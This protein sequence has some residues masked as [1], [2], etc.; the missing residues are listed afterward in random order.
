MAAWVGEHLLGLGVLGIGPTG[1]GDMAVHYVEVLMRVLGA[2]ALSLIW[3]L[4]DRHRPH[5]RRL[6]RWLVVGCRYYLMSVMLA[7]GFAK[8]FSGQF[9]PPTL[10][11]LL[12][13]FGDASPMGL[14]W[15]FMGASKAYSAFA[16]L[17]EVTGGLLLA[18]RRTTTLGA[19]VIVAVMS[20]V[21]M[22]NFSYDVPVKL[23]SCHLLALAFV[24]VA[25]DGRR[26]LGVL[27][28]NRSVAAASYPPH[29]TDPRRQ[30]ASRVAKVCV[31]GLFL[32]LSIRQGVMAERMYG[33]GAAKPP[34]WGIYDVETFTLDG[35]ILPPLLTDPQRWQNVVFDHRRELTVRMM[36]GELV[37]HSYAIEGAKKLKIYH[38]D[39]SRS[40][41]VFERPS[42]GVMQVEGEVDGRVVALEMRARDAEDFLLLKRGFHWVNEVPFNR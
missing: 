16:G 36:N 38:A 8:I 18:F 28:L 40:A 19:L 23:Y 29:F 5:Y 9:L 11:R 39:G 27:M 15:T 10:T 42:P 13:P 2:L 20:N 31:I 34:L 21:V 12:Q 33:R 1:S 25:I 22:M 30:R 7:Y 17:G 4:V 35:E 24:L 32:F 37:Q 14:L 26:V 3:T 41:W 6:G